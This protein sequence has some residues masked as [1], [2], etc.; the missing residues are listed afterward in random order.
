[1][2]TTILGAKRGKVGW[3]GQKTKFEPPIE[4]RV[5]GGIVREGEKGLYQIEYAKFHACPHP[6]H[7]HKWFG[8]PIFIHSIF[9]LHPPCIALGGPP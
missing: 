6:L 9:F 1:M 8:G 3:G 7:S 4:E 5:R 2:A